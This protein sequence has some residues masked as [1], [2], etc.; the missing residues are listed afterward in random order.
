MSAR[1]LEHPQIKQYGTPAE[2]RERLA[3]LG[4]DLPVDDVIDPS[5]D[6]AQPLAIADAARPLVAPNRF[7]ILPM[8]GWDAERDGAPSDLVRRRWRRF[9]SSGAGL[10]W[11]G[12][13]AAVRHDGRANPNQLVMADHTAEDVAGLRTELV[14]AAAEVGVAPVV[15]LQLTHSGRWS[16]PD[17][18]PAPR[19]ARLDPVLD[20]RVGA[21]EHTLLSDGELD[22]LAATFVHAAGLAAAAGFDFVDVK[23]CHGYLGHELLMAR[24]REGRYG[25]DLE[26]RTRFLRTV[27]AG[28][29]DEHPALGIGVR[30]SLYDPG[31]LRPGPDGVVE[32]VPG[33]IEG[34]GPVGPDGRPDLTEAVEVVRLLAGAGVRMVCTT[35]SSPYWAPAVQRPAWFPPSDGALPARDPLVDTVVM[36]AAARD[37]RAAAPEGTVV[38][39]TGFTY[40]QQHLPEVGQALLRQGWV[41]SVGLG[42][43]VL[44][45]PELPADVL[46]GRSLQPRKVCRTF[47]DCTTAPRNGLVSGCYPLD[48]FYKERPERVELAAVKRR[49]RAG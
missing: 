43:M 36:L 30:L 47:S 34:F 32:P 6:L 48:P 1:R 23:A 37:L 33:A 41:D 21:G 16:R 13:A 9:G 28:I 3:A 31:P 35:A 17:G 12:E 39:G 24:D 18:E 45:Y 4:L 14:E 5:A 15:G 11:G 27:V 10:V 22:E 25:G 7:A 49:M 40:L 26:G 19:T 38:V 2:L 42:R 29:R 8:E 46:A 20:E 44:S